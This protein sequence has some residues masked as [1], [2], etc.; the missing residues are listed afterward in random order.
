MVINIFRMNKSKKDNYTKCPRLNEV[1]LGKILL[2][3]VYCSRET[4]KGTAQQRR[5]QKT[6][7]NIIQT[8]LDNYKKVSYFVLVSTTKE[9]SRIEVKPHGFQPFAKVII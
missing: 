5:T 4:K 2:K 1:T 7:I 8:F 3:I 6:S 9:G